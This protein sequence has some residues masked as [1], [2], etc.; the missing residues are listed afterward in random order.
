MREILFRG[1]T[2]DKGNW[3]YGYYVGPAGLDNS[4]EIC[5]I[6]NLCGIRVDVDPA[7]VG[8]Y[9]G[10]TDQNGKKIY[11][12]DIISPNGY[13]WMKSKRYIVSME[14]DRAGWFPFA[15]GDGCGCCEDE[16]FSQGCCV[17]IGNVHDNPE[18]MR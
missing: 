12:G 9:T 10:L 15:R 14:T 1:K 3:V 8:Q 17:V 13:S 2:I 16:T 5:D 4:H 18:L 6:N 7:S 11:E